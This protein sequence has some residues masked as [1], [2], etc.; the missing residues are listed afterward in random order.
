MALVNGLGGAFVFSSEPARLAGWYAEM[1]G[2]RFEG[3][4]DDGQ[5]WLVF[6]ALNPQ[7]AAQKFDTTFAFIQATIPQDRQVPEQEPHSMYGDQPY[8]LNFRTDD[9][10]A[11]LE[12][13]EGKG[14]RILRQEDTTYG[15]FA[16]MRDL[17][18]N[19]VELYQPSRFEE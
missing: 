14:V 7:D 10:G 5:F 3:S 11:L 4:Q 6:W 17:D 19:R 13:L 2:S 15:R 8:M 16:W 9:L 18:G 12:H 1:F